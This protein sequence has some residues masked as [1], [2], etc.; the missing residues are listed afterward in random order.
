VAPERPFRNGAELQ[1]LR[2]ACVEGLWWCG[3]NGVWKRADKVPGSAAGSAEAV[4]AVFT[5]SVAPTVTVRGGSGSSSSSS[6]SDGLWDGGRGLD[7]GT[8]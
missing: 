7:V 2:T 1:E 6:S 5:L 8:R 4:D 3:P